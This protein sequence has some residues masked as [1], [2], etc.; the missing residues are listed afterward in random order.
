ME[1]GIGMKGVL[2]LAI[3]LMLQIVTN[4]NS[5]NEILMAGMGSN[6]FAVALIGI[7]GAI[8]LRDNGKK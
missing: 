4:N 3:I 6:S 8:L 5:S 1:E 7:L 2:L